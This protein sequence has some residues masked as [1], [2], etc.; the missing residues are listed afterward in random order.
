MHIHSRSWNKVRRGQALS[1]ALVLVLV[2]AI[3]GSGL[4]S[5]ALGGSRLASRRAAGT[6][7][8]N[9]AMAAADEAV[10]QLQSDPSWM[11]DGG[12]KQYTVPGPGG[13]QASLTLSLINDPTPGATEPIR[14]ITSKAL[15]EG[16]PLGTVSR[17]VD[18]YLGQDGLMGKA[19]KKAIAAK[20][21]IQIKGK[22]WTTSEVK[23]D[24]NGVG[25]GDILANRF[26][27]FKKKVKPM[28]IDAKGKRKGDYMIDGDADAVVGIYG[29]TAN[30][31]GAV[32]RGVEP[33][34]FP[35]IDSAWL[36]AHVP[37]QVVYPP[38]NEKRSPHNEHEFKFG[39]GHDYPEGQKKVDDKD[40]ASADTD[41]VLLP[42]EY[43]AADEVAG[44]RDGKKYHLKVKIGKQGCT[45]PDGAVVHIYGNLDVK[46]P[47]RGRG[48]IIC[49][50][51]VKVSYKD[52]KGYTDSEKAQYAEMKKSV[53]DTAAKAAL[54][55]VW[56]QQKVLFVSLLGPRGKQKPE[57]VEGIHIHGG[58][59]HMDVWGWYYA[60]NSRLKA[61][62]KP[63]IHGALVAN[64]VKAE[65]EV[66]VIVPAEGAAPPL[67]PTLTV[68][69]WQERA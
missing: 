4:L 9:V 14:R 27:K 55:A 5:L 60:P 35:T 10:S 13:G 31:K 54:N 61:H 19:F 34:Q 32:R 37:N 53:G 46:G 69:G 22:V 7:A 12:K 17:T 11:A 52:Y 25:D 40:S 48:T 51:K 36:T 41:D 26:L 47:I 30:V 39:D 6:K 58:G 16:G 62:G 57:K 18:V 20:T 3:V 64:L 24:P 29:S 42:G 66:K 63:S 45:I 23:T 28:T 56:M 50:G 44:P 38:T 65:G 15:V 67:P 1:T 59:K 43:R 68:L 33:L 8:L 21:D 2:V 49:E